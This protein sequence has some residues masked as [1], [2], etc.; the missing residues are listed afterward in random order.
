MHKHSIHYK[1]IYQE[2]DWC[3]NQFVINGLNHE[4]MAKE[5]SCSKRVVEKWCVEKHGLTQKFRQ[6]NTELNGIQ[7][8]LIIGSL[9]G[10]GHIDKRP[11][12]PIFIVS[13]AENQKDYLFFKYDLLKKLCNKEPSVIKE[14]V[15]DFC[16]KLY[17]CQ[18]QYRICTRIYDCLLKYRSMSNIELL[19]SLNEFSLSIWMLDDGHRD[20]TN[21]Q[22]CVAE[23]SSED[24]NYMFKILEEKFG[25]NFRIQKDIRYVTFDSPSSRALDKMILKNIPNDLDIIKYKIK[26]KVASK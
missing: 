2:Y 7:H 8:D 4:Q 13:H 5:A 21:W 11:T 17:K 22:L 20:K 16:G 23:Y 12:Q 18:P 6:K 3:F 25:L 26:D 10:D 14:S 9:L 24:M 19:S 15:K 1:D